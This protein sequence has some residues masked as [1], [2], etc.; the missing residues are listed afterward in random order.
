[1]SLSL[2][3]SRRRD[4]RASFALAA[5]SVGLAAG[6]ACAPASAADIMAT[7]AKSA[8]MRACTE[9]GEGF[10][11]LPGTDTCLRVGG[12]LW[13][14]GYFNTYTDYP[15]ANDKTYSIAT[16]GVILD[17]RTSTEYG[18]LRSYFEGRFKWR[19]ADPWS[20]GPNKSELEVWNAYIQFGGFTFGKAQSFFDFYANANVLGTD[21]ATIGDDVRLNLLAYT[22]EFGSSGFSAT[23]SL[24]SAADR[25]NGV[26]A[27]N[28]FLPLGNEDLSAGISAT[29]I[30]G[31]VKYAGT[32]GEAQISGALHQTNSVNV[33][34]QFTTQDTW[35]YALQ[36]GIMF[37]LDALAE[38]DTL[39]IQSAYADGAISY[40]GLVDPSGMYAPP[41]AFM[42][43]TGLTTVTG[44]NVTASF[45][46]HWNEKWSTAVFGGYAAYDLND[47][48]AQLFYGFSG[49]TNYN[50]G[51]YLAFNPVKALTIALQYDYTY[52][53]A[54]D[55]VPTAFGPSLAST[56]A[57]QVLLFVS[58]DF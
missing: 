22:Y 13:A 34:N 8:Y 51:G 36:A 6:A 54:K 35:G 50:V 26:L 17:A 31:N 9:Q 19:S 1:M 49:G 14:E 30:V 48:S 11:Y 39:Y 40:L 33:L 38:G 46:H 29:D 5:A 52:N 47:P 12:Y 43:V 4:R 16:A 28:P 45:L 53:S 10:F 2:S 24:E 42:S 56:D 58:R 25:N 41:D 3:S 27:Q 20:D 32:W 18:T 21:P 37:K 23:I 57:S 55:Y 15:A 44:W 7:K